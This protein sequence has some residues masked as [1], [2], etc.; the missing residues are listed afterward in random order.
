MTKKLI[1]CVSYLDDTYL[2]CY[3]EVICA[4]SRI[5]I[6]TF[7]AECILS[8]MQIIEKE[9]FQVRKI[10]GWRN[11]I[12]IL[13][14]E[15]RK[16]WVIYDKI[17]KKVEYKSF[18]NECFES[19]EAI[20]VGDIL[21]LLPISITNPIVV[22]N[23]LK[24]KV[25]S[26]INMCVPQIEV[27][28]DMNI[29]DANIDQGNICFMIRNSFYY[30][31]FGKNGI[32]IVKIKVTKP[33]YCAY[34]NDGIG[35]GIDREGKC[36]YKFDKEGNLLKKY[37]VKNGIQF[38]K[39][40]V[41]NRYIL[42]LPEN[43]NEIRILSMEGQEI[44]KI[45][46]EEKDLIYEFPELMGL[47]AYWCYVKRKKNIW[48]LP[49]KYSLKVLNLDSLE[50]KC[51]IIKYVNLNSGDLYEKYCKYVRDRKNIYRFYENLSDF[52]L[53][54]YL[55]MIKQYDFSLPQNEM[56]VSNKIW[57]KMN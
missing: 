35:W 15:I 40:I 14:V 31:R 42:L 26:K 19:S 29:W 34:F 2:W 39:I 52:K 8:P 20:L 50:W 56:F 6:E 21:V 36:I 45:G 37:F 41:E 48:F 33:L 24:R 17:E 46:T 43:S 3:D 12:I 11:K 30:G 9:T 5:N 7:Q 10:I 13:P 28:R 32:S 23:L 25:I 18:C 47:P 44:Y 53:N 54:R 49:L 22:I 4:L 38:T 27:K 51:K 57:K 16:K 1:S 55:E